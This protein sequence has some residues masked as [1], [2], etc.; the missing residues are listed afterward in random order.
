MINN[1]ISCFEEI[2]HPADW[3]IR[4]CASSPEALF[5][6]C[7]LGMYSLLKVK[8]Q[9]EGTP[10]S[11]KFHL[12]GVDLE[13]LLVSFLSELLFYYETEKIV[14]TGMNIRI[15]NN[16]LEAELDGKTIESTL[17]EIKAVTYHQMK[18]EQNP[19]GLSV[20]VVFDV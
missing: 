5:K 20:M 9:I 3:A 12:D 1:N 2:Q 14:F 18:I 15:Q 4:V 13:S 10:R 8:H 6:C 16:K 11:K 7:A 17:V 19:H